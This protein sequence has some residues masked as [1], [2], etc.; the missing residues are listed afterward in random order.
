M[1]NIKKLILIWALSATSATLAADDSIDKVN[2][3]LT[4]LNGVIQSGNDELSSQRAQIGELK[5]ELSASN[6]ENAAL[7]KQLFN[8][9]KAVQRQNQAMIDTLS[10]GH[11]IKKQNEDGTIMEVKPLRNYDLQTPD[12]KFIFGAQEY[13]YVKEVNATFSARI[14]TGAT[15]S[16]ISAQNISEFERKGKKWI[17]FD[18]VTNDRTVT[19]EAPFVR[20]AQVRQTQSGD[21]LVDRIVVRLNVKF[22][23]YSTSTEFNLIDRSKMQHA[24]LIGRSLLTD[25]CVVDVS[26]AYVQK[27]ADP[28]GLIFLTRDDYK[29]AVK[30]GI[31][32]NKTYDEKEKQNVAGLAASPASGDVNMGSDSE[33]NLPGVSARLEQNLQQVKQETTKDDEKKTGK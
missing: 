9:L 23:D 2:D 8:E 17:R 14:D 13:I 1:N 4:S 27:R 15:V 7:K 12:G 24:L 5:A 21:N 30:K 3:K 28:D 22:G 18:V 33:K 26:R 25:I 20:V 10:A 32:P 11:T 29:E 16:S 31:N 19:C 6:E